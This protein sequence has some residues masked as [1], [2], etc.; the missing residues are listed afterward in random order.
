[1][2]VRCQPEC[3]LVVLRNLAESSLERLPGFVLHTTVL[4]EHR[5]VILPVEALGPTKLV[6]VLRELVCTDWLKLIPKTL[7]DFGFEDIQ[8]HSVDGILQTGVLAAATGTD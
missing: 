8:A 2:L 3:P 5:K 6:D 1:M 7:L 4:D